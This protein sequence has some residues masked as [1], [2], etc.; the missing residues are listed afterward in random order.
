M[1]PW[2]ESATW[3]SL[4]HLSLDMAIGHLTTMFV[5]ATVVTAMSLLVFLPLS[6][7]VIWIG[8]LVARA[9]AQVERSRYAALLDLD[10]TDTSPPLQ[11]R[12]AWWRF[13][14]RFRSQQ[15][16]REWLYLAFHL[17]VGIGPVKTSV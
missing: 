1:R 10:L 12:N 16:W 15:R 8:F 4:V 13:L 14:E 6:I 3:W 17:P 2:R 5:F 11:G 7:L 9:M